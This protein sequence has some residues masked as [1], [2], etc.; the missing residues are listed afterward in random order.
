MAPIDPL[1]RVFHALADPIRRAILERLS[2]GSATV[3]EL[4]EPFDV[5]APAVSQHLRVLEG[6]GLIER[7]TRAQWRICTIRT[8]PLDAASQWVD[9]NRALWSSRVDTLDDVLARIRPTGPDT[10]KESS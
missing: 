9:E 8:E 5:S 6:A 7:T 10:T 4:S 2:G 3:G 1:S